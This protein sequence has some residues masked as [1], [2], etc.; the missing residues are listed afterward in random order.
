MPKFLTRIIV[1]ASKDGS[2]VVA[3]E[4]Q[5]GLNWRTKDRYVVQALTQL[6]KNPRPWMVIF[7]A[8]MQ[9]R[10]KAAK[11]KAPAQTD[12]SQPLVEVEA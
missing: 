2:T 6:P 9:E 5:I 7:A 1:S 3:L 8:D 11:I 10:E 12:A 4:E